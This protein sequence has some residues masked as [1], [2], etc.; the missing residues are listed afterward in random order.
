M[1]ALAAERRRQSSGGGE[2]QVCLG[3]SQAP[4]TG[5]S[6]LPLDKQSLAVQPK[7]ACSRLRVQTAAAGCTWALGSH[8]GRAISM[9]GARR[10]SRR[11]CGAA[12]GSPLGSCGGPKRRCW[13]ADEPQTDR[14]ALHARDC[15]PKH[16]A[17]A[18]RRPAAASGG[19]G[20]I[21]LYS[22]H[23][24]LAVLECQLHSWWCRRSAATT[25]HVGGTPDEWMCLAAHCIPLPSPPT[26]LICEVLRHNQQGR[27][28]TMGDG[29]CA[30][31]QASKTLHLCSSVGGGS[32]AALQ[33]PTALQCEDR[34]MAA[35]NQ[36]PTRRCSNPALHCHHFRVRV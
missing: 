6:V 4:D 32:S 28:G 34:S 18:R 33:P 26:S 8:T 21:E 2:Q 25:S 3:W 11:P 9:W 7:P 35:S 27:Q 17:A 16:P 12:A 30:A 24:P 20:C 15:C 22:P 23:V 19:I 1:A 10:S 29:T 31:D 14:T 5:M 13:P 36:W